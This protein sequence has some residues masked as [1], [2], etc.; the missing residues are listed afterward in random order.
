MTNLINFIISKHIQ[1]LR[2]YYLKRSHVST[3]EGMEKILVSG[4]G[5]QWLVLGLKNK[6]ERSR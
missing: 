6:K 2:Q 1:L 3:R 5:N 4:C